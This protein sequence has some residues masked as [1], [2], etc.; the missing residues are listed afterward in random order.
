M[1]VK[2][3]RGYNN[4]NNIYPITGNREILLFAF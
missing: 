3:I 1:A 4:M 2:V